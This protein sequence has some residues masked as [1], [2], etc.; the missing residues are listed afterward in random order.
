MQ[1]I[2]HLRHTHKAVVQVTS[3]TLPL[4]FLRR[5]QLGRQFFQ[6]HLL[7]MQF[8]PVA[9]ERSS[10]CLRSVMSTATPPNSTG[11]PL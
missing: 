8:Q 9:M 6:L 5:Q 3:D 7:L 1:E 11:V 2:R 4:M 10:V